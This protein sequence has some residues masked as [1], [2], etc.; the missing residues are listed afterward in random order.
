MG[1][2]GWESVRSR[3]YCAGLTVAKREGSWVDD[4]AGQIGP[5][6]LGVLGLLVRNALDEA[7]R[8]HTRK[9]EVE[10]ADDAVRVEDDGRGLPVHPHP[11]SKRPLLE[12]MLTGARRGYRAGTSG[13]RNGLAQV[14]A[15][16]MWVH[17]RVQRDGWAWSQGYEFGRPG[18]G[19][20][21]VRPTLLRGTQITCAP[22]LG[23][24]PSVGEVRA[25]VEGATEEDATLGVELV[26]RDRRTSD[27][28]TVSV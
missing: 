2:R 21:R 10:W 22:V 28:E 5:D 6:F 20:E 12:V 13:A 27:E 25:W 9:I 23:E 4:E 14:N 1:G 17:V 18:G 15:W 8:G 16:S 26:L 24:A 7:R 19:L 3:G 11:Q